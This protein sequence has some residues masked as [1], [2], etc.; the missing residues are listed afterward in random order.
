MTAPT[1]DPAVDL[2]HEQV[3]VDFLTAASGLDPRS[4]IPTGPGTTIDDPHGLFARA[5]RPGFGPWLTQAARLRGCVRPIRLRGEVRT[6]DSAGNLVDTFRT[7]DLP[8]GVLYKPCGTRYAALCPACA[9][10]YRWDTYQLIRAGLSGGK[11]VA[12]TVVRHPAVFATLTAPSFGPVHTRVV[13]PATGRVKP[14]RARRDKPTCP[15]GRS[16]W[17]PHGHQPGDRR[18]GQPFCLDCYDHNHQ[19]VWNHHVPKLWDRTIVRLRRL[20][21]AE[22]GDALAD[23]TRLSFV[24]VAEMQA[25]AAIHL[26]ALIRFD[27][28]DRERPDDILPPPVVVAPDDT[29]QPVLSA[30]R[31]A[32]L[33]V[34]AA[35]SVAVQTEPHPEQAD[36]WPVVWG[37]Q[38][39][40]KIVRH[41]LDSGDLTEGHVAG[42][43][44]KYATKGSEAAGLVACRI[45]P[46]TVGAYNDPSTHVGRLI[47]ACWRLG[48]F[49]PGLRLSDQDARPYG[50]LRKWAHMFGFG[51]HF[52]TKSRRYSTTLGKLRAARVHHARAIARGL[53]PEQ[54]GDLDTD[55]TNV[56]IGQWRYT[57][58]GWLTTGDAALAT[59]AAD[60]ARQRRPTNTSRP[61]RDVAVP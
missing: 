59:M 35:R 22:L 36:G 17:C 41:G 37:R 11:G 57:G 19:V 5:T 26:H 16:L 51:G 29:L 61:G 9:E 3:L 27:G 20:V 32:Q 4:G 1:T 46:T 44:A 15:H 54:L 48:R 40:A 34:L 49:V 55:D 14:C 53:T 10:T 47:A 24:K 28:R 43:L 52:S 12:D 31:L 8:D 30:E 7:E 18:L 38:I 6:L 50:R 56:V 21:A 39:D 13:N 2:G 60:A 25:R 23:I 58:T 33:V 42:Y 45:T